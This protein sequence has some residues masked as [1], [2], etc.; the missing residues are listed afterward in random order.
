MMQVS[1]FPLPRKGW[2][3]AEILLALLLTAMTT[4]GIFFVMSASSRNTMNAYHIYLAEQLA[5]E[6]LEVL[7]CTSFAEIAAK[8]DTGIGE[9]RF[10]RW[11]RIRP[12]TG[13]D[14]I[15]RPP[16][17]EQFERKISAELIQHENT[18]GILLKVFVRPLTTAQRG[19]IS[20]CETINSGI[21]IER[22]P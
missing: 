4:G 17:A 12:V 8:L 19:L 1:C 16:E 9:Y 7:R 5:G 21:I 20:R 6:P 2:S 10:N 3:L 11:Q 22:T 14:I 15:N 13:R 18:R